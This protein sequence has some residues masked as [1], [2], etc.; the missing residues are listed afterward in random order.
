MSYTMS[1][2]LFKRSSKLNGTIP[3]HHIVVADAIP[4]F[5]FMPIVDVFGR[6]LLP[7][8]DS[9]AMNDNECDTSHAPIQD[10]VPS[11]V[12]TAAKIL[13]RV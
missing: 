10:V 3:P 12:T 2:R 5:V 9:R 4:S 7:R 1:P 8:T 6:A 11:A 13:I